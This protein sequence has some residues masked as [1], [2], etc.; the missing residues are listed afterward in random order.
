MSIYLTCLLFSLV[1]KLSSHSLCKFCAEEGSKKVVS[2]KH[3]FI[4]ALCYCYNLYRL[5]V[6]ERFSHL[7]PLSSAVM[8]QAS[9]IHQES[10]LWLCQLQYVLIQTGIGCNRKKS[11]E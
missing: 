6:P 1:R 2:T 3:K 7:K 5:N 4:K 8:Y 11:E 10:A 9:N